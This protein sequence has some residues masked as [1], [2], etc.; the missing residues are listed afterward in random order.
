MLIL[1]VGC[2]Q[3]PS[4]AAMISRSLDMLLGLSTPSCSGELGWSGSPVHVNSCLMQLSTMFEH[5]QPNRDHRQ[6]RKFH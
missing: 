6:S 5:A 1:E 2:E 4:L 3:D